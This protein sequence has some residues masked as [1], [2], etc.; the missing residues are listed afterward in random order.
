MTLADIWLLIAI[1]L[2]IFQ[3]WRVRAITEA[4]NVYAS[5]YCEQQQLQLLSLARAKTRLKWLRG[6][7]DWYT[8]F[9]FEFSGNGE[10]KYTGTLIMN[11]LRVTQT[12]VPPYRIP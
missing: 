5:R 6:K 3:F 7:L 8:E 10:D 12:Q 2:V 4:A 9:Q 1:G 11:G